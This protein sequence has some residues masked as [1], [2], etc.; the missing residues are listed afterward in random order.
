MTDGTFS[1]GEIPMQEKRI[2]T[3]RLDEL[4]SHPQQAAL[5]SD[6]NEAEFEKLKQSVEKGL[7]HPIEITT[8]NVVIDGHQRL[9]AARG[10]GLE[11]ID[12]W[13]RDDLTDEQAISRRHIEANLDRRQ[14]TRLEQARLMKALCD[15]ERIKRPRRHDAHLG[16]V[17]DRIGQ[18]FG[19]DG[20]TAGRWMNVLNTPPAIQKAVS[21]G[22]LTMILAEKVSHLK[23]DL[24]EYVA[25]RIDGGEDPAHVVRDVQKLRWKSGKQ[26]KSVEKL[27]DIAKLLDKV[28]VDTDLSVREAQQ[29]VAVLTRCTERCRALAA[30]L[31][32]LTK[33]VQADS[34]NSQ[35]AIEDVNAA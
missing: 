33:A 17:R 28:K 22:K 8:E 21:E 12:V 13:V 19:M 20:R 29:G 32:R 25:G 15:L 6:L 23:N 10:L 7:D 31:E 4:K 18:R 35:S 14:L 26:P 2:E 5:F 16:D 34:G 30:Q 3:R 1:K 24:M 9:R 27:A 11:T